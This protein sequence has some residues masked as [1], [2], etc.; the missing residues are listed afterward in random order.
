MNAELYNQI[1]NNENKLISTNEHTSGSYFRF[2]PIFNIL[3]ETPFKFKNRI[4]NLTIV[5]KISLT[6]SPGIS[7]EDLTM[8]LYVK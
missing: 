1:F 7:N 5:P 2:F 6:L 4:P 8:I 3:S